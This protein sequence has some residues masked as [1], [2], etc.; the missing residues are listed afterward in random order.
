MVELDSAAHR[1]TLLSETGRLLQFGRAA[2]LPAGGFGWLDTRGAVTVGRPA[3]LYVTGR[4]THVYSIGSL[5][6]LAG[7][8]HLVDH[9]LLAL[10]SIFHDM[11]N[12][13]WYEAI[14]DEGQVS[15]PRKTTYGLAFVILAGASASYA[16]RP[17]A[18]ELLEAALAVSER[19]VWE[20]AEGMVVDS[21]DRTF[22]QL[23]DYRGVNST[24][25][26]VEAYLAAYAATERSVWLDR[27][28]KMTERVLGF[29]RDAGWRLPEHFD[30]RWEPR[31]DH[32]RDRPQD[33]TRPFGATV[34]HWLEWSRLVLQVRA[35]LAGPEGPVHD[36]LLDAAVVLFDAAVRDGWDVDGR[37]GFVYT[38]DWDG[39]VV[40]KTRLHWVLCEALGAAATL[41]RVTGQER[42]RRWY[43]TWWAYAEAHLL[44]VQ[45]G[46]WHHEL[47]ERNVPSETIR[48]G[49]ADL[50]H[51]VQA[52]LLPLLP[53]GPSVAQEVKAHLL[54]AGRT[55]DPAP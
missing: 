37:P 54:D 28:L 51:A 5:L 1:R 39:H 47:D 45:N 21:W 24:M 11:Q 8:D 27:A 49:K 48:P 44:D 29:A 53:V 12:G 43:A 23:D 52:V 46:S 14:D 34:G 2:A 36:R 26:T 30:A 9:G 50:Y 6:G 19:H 25:H 22:S 13:G 33:P 20:E 10:S 32:N 40:V 17:G 15:D 31:L 7:S 55:I 18:P 3:Q 38:V 35:S 4:M 41:A 42:F 16:G